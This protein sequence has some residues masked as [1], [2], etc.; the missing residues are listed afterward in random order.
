MRWKLKASQI[1]N[2]EVWRS[3]INEYNSEQFR[4]VA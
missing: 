1:S 2:T 3:N 4:P